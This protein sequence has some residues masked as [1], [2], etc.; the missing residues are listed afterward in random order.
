MKWVP[1]IAALCGMAAST[2]QQTLLASAAPTIVASYHRPTMYAWIPGC[3]L[4][5]SA[6][7]LPWAGA[8][9]DRVG[10]RPM[11]T[12]GSLTFI[13]GSVGSAVAPGPA[14]FLISRAVQGV[15][16]GLLVPAALVVVSG[17]R[18]D[19]DRGRAYGLVGLVQVVAN[20]VG[21]PLGG[22]FTDGVGWRWGVGA[23]TPLAIIGLLLARRSM[24]TKA[25]PSRWWQLTARELIDIHSSMTVRRLLAAS[26]FVGGLT[27]SVTTYLP[28]SLIYLHHLTASQSGWLLVPTLLASATGSMIGGAAARQPLALRVTLGSLLLAF[29]LALTNTVPALAA[30]GAVIGLCCGAALPIILTRVQDASAPD[31]IALNTSWIQLSRHAGAAVIVPAIGLWATTPS[32]SSTVGIFASLTVVAGFAAVAAF[33]VPQHT[34]RRAISGD[35]IDRSTHN[36]QE[37]TSHEPRRSQ[38]FTNRHSDTTRRSRSHRA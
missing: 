20:V 28:W 11:Y 36:P 21:P 2:L 23:S 7:T 15:G 3:Y 6:L 13:S 34:P 32:L 38:L 29:P 1:L 35:P 10:P 12:A 9:T 14:L 31:Q 22:W 24:T 18:N 5:T 19:H 30:A 33:C 4:L 27:V 25:A 16:A 8:I 37:R 17:L 26:L